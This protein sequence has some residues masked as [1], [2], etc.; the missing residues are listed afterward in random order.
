[1][2]VAVRVRPLN[3][4]ETRQG[5]VGGAERRK[6]RSSPT[7]KKFE[8][9]DPKSWLVANAGSGGT[10]VQRG[11]RQVEG[12]S[13]FSF[14]HVF[15]E[16]IS[17]VDLY[18]AVVRPITKGVFYGQHGTVF[19]YGQTGSGKT[20]T[21]QGE[22]NNNNNDGDENNKSAGVIALAARDLFER[23]DE[24]GQQNDYKV[25]VC[26]L[27]IYN[28]TVRDLLASEVGKVRRTRSRSP[29]SDD[30]LHVAE[31]PTLTI[32]DDPRRGGVHVDCVV[33]EVSDVDA[34]M[35]VLRRGNM[36]RST[37]STKLNER[38]SRSHAIFRIMLETT[39]HETPEADTQG[40]VRLSN[41]NLVDLAGSENSRRSGATNQRQR[42]GGKINK[43]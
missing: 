40:I 26:Y 5:G 7:S 36:N 32:R 22:N 4:D 14:D 27:E 8:A 33:K 1:M 35:G 23:L 34:L 25:R 17:T 41:L 16:H 18:H 38:S 31:L 6:S 19:A 24:S 12:K 11:V 2:P 37:A 42:E 13:V 20:F 29:T 21:M 15:D 28:E 3:H 10:L 30:L 39:Q 43:R 9:A